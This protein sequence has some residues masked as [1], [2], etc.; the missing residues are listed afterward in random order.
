M[1]ICQH[2]THIASPQLA[3]W[4]MSY[5]YN[6]LAVMKKQAETFAG[7]CYLAL[8]AAKKSREILVIKSQRL[9]WLHRHIM[10]NT[11]AWRINH[12]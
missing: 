10:R 12:G 2:F 11:T 5:L 9:D 4:Y 3:K 8:S 1:E 6:G 7:R